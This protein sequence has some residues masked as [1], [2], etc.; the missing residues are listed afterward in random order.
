MMVALSNDEMVTIDG[1]DFTSGYNA[2]A[3]AGDYVRRVLDD[4]GILDFFS[5][6]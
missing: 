3:A 2:G 1:G 4:C 6:L 5:H